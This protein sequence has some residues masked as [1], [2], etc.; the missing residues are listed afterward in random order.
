MQGVSIAFLIPVWVSIVLRIYVRVCMAKAFGWDDG[1]MILAAMSFTSFAALLIVIAEY[2]YNKTVVEAYTTSDFIG[3]WN[4][5]G[6]ALEYTLIYNSLYVLT[7]ILFKISLAIFFLRIVVAKWQR[8]LIIIPTALFTAYSLAYMFITTFRCGSPREILLNTARGKCLPTSIVSPL[9]YVSGISNALMDVMFACLPTFVLWHSQMPKKTK[10]SCCILLSMGGLGCVASIIRIAFLSGVSDQAHYFSNAINTGLVSIVEPGLAITAASLGT[11]RPLFQLVA[12]KTSLASWQSSNSKYAASESIGHPVRSAIHKQL[13]GRLVLRSVTTWE[14]LLLYVLHPIYLFFCDLRS[15]DI[16]SVTFAELR[17][18]F[19]PLITPPRMDNFGYD[20][21][22]PDLDLPKNNDK[23]A[24]GQN[25]NIPI[26]SPQQCSSDFY[27]SAPVAVTVPHHLTPLPSVLLENPMNLLYYHYFINYTANVLVTHQCPSNPFST[28]LPRLATED[29]NLLRLLLAYAACHRARLLR[30]AEPK[31][32]IATWV[33]PVFPSLRQALSGNEPI[34][35]SAFG[36]CVML[37]S[38]TQSYPL[39]FDLPISWQEHL[40]LA[41][42]LYS[43]R[44]GQEHLQRTNATIFFGRW[45]AYLDTFGSAS[46]D[47]YQ[48]AYYEWSRELKMAEQIPELQCL[49]GFTTKSLCLLSRT[50][51]LAKRCDYERRLH[52]QPAVQTITMSQQLRMNLELFTLEIKHT[53]YDCACS[54]SSTSST[55]VYRAVNAAISHAAL[56]YLHRRVYMLPSESRLVQFSVNAILHA[57]N[58]L[59][60][61]NAFDTPDIILPLFLAGCEAR[62]PGK[63]VDVLQR[64]QSI[65]NAGMGQVVRVKALLQECWDT[66][67]DWTELKHNVLLG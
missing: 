46:S 48:G 58:E 35:D 22:L 23:D 13:N 4:V 20:H 60:G 40:S 41:R 7:T 37:A 55:E 6:T 53:R 66:K 34:T 16:A 64:L 63:A 27:Y 3:I 43:L 38:L 1:I 17:Y 54:Q 47:T 50:A 52:G 28:I 31:N 36:S 51:E 67:R 42:R 11:L 45:F 29:D 21:G 26:D 2:P 25:T 49:A 44:L 5:L 9:L 61:Y 12:E 57:F 18:A 59:K 19:I 15:C 30:H 8:R 24:L 10:I 62:D 33:T 32:R 56:I 65:E 39:A 14:Y